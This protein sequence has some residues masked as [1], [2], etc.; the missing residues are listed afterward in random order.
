MMFRDSRQ[1]AFLS[2][3]GEASIRSAAKTIRKRGRQTS[4]HAKTP[5]WLAASGAIFM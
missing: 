3:I 2:R 4:V 1:Y 5:E